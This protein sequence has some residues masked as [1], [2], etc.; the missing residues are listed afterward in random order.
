MSKELE[1]DTISKFNRRKKQE[2]KTHAYVLEH[3]LL[4]M[5]RKEKRKNRDEG[6]NLLVKEARKK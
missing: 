3:N 5:D 4:L 6:I 1:N 2:R